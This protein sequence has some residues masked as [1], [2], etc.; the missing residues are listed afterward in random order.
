MITGVINW[1]QCGEEELKQ[2]WKIVDSRTSRR[3][4][5][6]LGWWSLKQG[7]FYLLLLVSNLCR[8]LLRSIT[9]KNQTGQDRFLVDW[10]PLLARQE[11]RQFWSTSLCPGAASAHFRQPVTGMFDYDQAKALSC[12]LLV[13]YAVNAA[14]CLLVTSLHV[15]ASPSFFGRPHRLFAAKAYQRQ[16]WCLSGDFN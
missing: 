15:T 6:C 2:L 5:P 8:V 1:N 13:W 11:I 7:I 4:G 10:L 12:W 3:A 14:T 9:C 16:E